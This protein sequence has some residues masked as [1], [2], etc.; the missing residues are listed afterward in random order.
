MCFFFGET[1]Y[2]SV[3]IVYNKNKIQ[4]SNKTSKIS[5]NY[6]LLEVFTMSKYNIGVRRL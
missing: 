1:E 3:A 6:R 2:F 4:I 5:F